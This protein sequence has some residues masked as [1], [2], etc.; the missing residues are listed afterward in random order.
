M[1][2]T[3]Y[4]RNDANF[5]KTLAN[6]SNYDSTT[7]IAELI[8]NSIGAKANI[9]KV[10]V[11]NNVFKISDFGDDAGMN[12]I[13]FEH[14]FFK[15]GSSSTCNDNDAAGVFG[16]GGKTG[17]LAII[18]NEI[19]TDVEILT[20]KKGYK[21][22]YAKWEVTRGRCDRCDI[23]LL[24]DDSYP[25]GTSISFTFGNN[26]DLEELVTFIGVTYCW[27]I[28]NGVQIYV[29]D[30]LVDACDPFYREHEVVKSNKLFCTK[31]FKVAGE[32]VIVNTVGFKDDKLI[33]CEDLNN[34]DRST[35]KR[36]GLRTT[37]RSGIY[38]RTGG[39]YFTLGGNFTRMTGISG[40]TT[41]NGMRVEV[42]VP[43]S[44]W[45]TIGILWNK[46][47]VKSFTKVTDFITGCQKTGVL[48]YIIYKMNRFSTDKHEYNTKTAN[49]LTKEFALIKANNNITNINV[50]AFA[51]GLKKGRF[52]KY[53]KNRLTFDVTFSP[54]DNRKDV[55]GIVKSVAIV[56]DTLVKNKCS[57]ALIDEVIERF[58]TAPIED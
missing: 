57:K 35:S 51:S 10:Y 2:K 44:L 29:N 31:S 4:L 28:K 39:R 50:T 53:E 27:N 11:N 40:N 52:I 9:V 42:I 56:V 46:S 47:G 1:S 54:T 22:L 24:N 16:V 26:I 20:H 19:A 43:K 17:I 38:V 37:N 48:D 23:D 3:I 8:D 5:E 34:Y 33:P 30:E 7:A 36:G 49:A 13:T 55:Y 25:F 21:P 15:N 58:N 18:G 41:Y 12:E 14:N 32:T 45:D 6:N